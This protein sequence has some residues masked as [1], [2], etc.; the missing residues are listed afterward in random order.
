MF[1]ILG[2]LYNLTMKFFV[3]GRSSNIEEIK[4]VMACIVEKGH[5]I[6]LDWTTFPMAKPYK[7]N[8]GLAG[9]FATAQIDGIAASDVYI[10]LAHHDGTGVFSELG[11][12]LALSQL[13]GKLK[14][15]GIAS[16]I[17]EAMFHYHPA[18]IWK[19]S[20]DE[21]FTELGI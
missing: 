8:K 18:I 9:K 5:E 3:T 15:Y 16:D 2:L 13:H 7:E 11:A 6:S 4:S 20:I 14:I 17:P 21:V 19:N 1:I 10:L 12:A